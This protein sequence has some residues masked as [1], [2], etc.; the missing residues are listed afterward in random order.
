M[1]EEIIEIRRKLKEK[2]SY[3]LGIDKVKRYENGLETE[4]LAYIDDSMHPIRFCASREL[5]IEKVR[6]DDRVLR[7][8]LLLDSALEE[9]ERAERFVEQKRFKDAAKSFLGSVTY[10]LNAFGMHSLGCRFVELSIFEIADKLAELCRDE[11][12]S[13]NA[14]A[15]QK[16]ADVVKLN[17]VSVKMMR[18]AAKNIIERVLAVML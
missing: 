6:E 10:A 4:F 5:K 3:W 17:E 7:Q 9:F 12:I 8:I 2:V 16:I 15:L 13:R 11:S 14:R 1:I 18:D